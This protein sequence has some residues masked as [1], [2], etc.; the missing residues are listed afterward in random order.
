[1]EVDCIALL[2]VTKCA[3]VIVKY[4]HKSISKRIP[5]H[6]LYKLE[7][8]SQLAPYC[9]LNVVSRQ[10]IHFMVLRISV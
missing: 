1:M 5:F 4:M 6:T 2:K 10:T 8:A 3:E 7:I 9:I